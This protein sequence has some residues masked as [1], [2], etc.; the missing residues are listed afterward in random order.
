MEIRLKKIDILVLS[1]ELMMLISRLEEILELKYR[2]MT[3]LH[4]QLINSNCLVVN[5]KKC[6]FFTHF[7]QLGLN[8]K[9]RQTIY[10]WKAYDL[11]IMKKNIS[12]STCLL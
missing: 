2:A 11:K 7:S 1:T 5:L 12:D 9:L 3:N 6:P 8:S 10:P 4:Y